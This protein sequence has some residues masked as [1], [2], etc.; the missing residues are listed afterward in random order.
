MIYKFDGKKK[1]FLEAYEKTLG[2]ITAS[3]KSAGVSRQTYY[4]WVEQD[5]HFS[6]AISDLNESALDVAESV[7][8][9]IIVKQKN[10]V[11][12]IFYLKTKGKARGYV[13]KQ[14]V[15]LSGQIGLSGGSEMNADKIAA[16]KKIV[17]GE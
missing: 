15:D 1:A 11:A 9:E 7:L 8:K 16:L 10:I 17:E 5:E 12:V 13:E 3:C 6:T 2:N 14:E 4:N